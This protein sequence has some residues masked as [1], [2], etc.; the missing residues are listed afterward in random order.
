VI[1][2][3]TTALNVQSSAATQRSATLLALSCLIDSGYELHC[4]LDSYS[5][6]LVEENAIATAWVAVSNSDSNWSTSWLQGL[7]ICMLL[8]CG[9]KSIVDRRLC[10]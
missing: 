3:V 7:L 2:P 8:F 5:S 4:Q 1:D 6:S 10:F 9:I